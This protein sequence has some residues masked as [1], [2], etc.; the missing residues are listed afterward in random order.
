MT[1]YTNI[2]NGSLPDATLVMANFN[3]LALPF[4]IYT[5]TGFNST[6]SGG[7]GTDEQSVELTAITTPLPTN[8]V[9]IEITYAAV[10]T[11][12]TGTTPNASI[13]IQ[14]KETGGAYGDILA[15][16]VVSACRSGS[17]AGEAGETSVTNTIKYI[18]TPTAGEKANG[19]QLKVFSKSITDGA[20][21]TAN[22]T[23]VQTLVYVL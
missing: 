8:Y 21:D 17:N 4:Q 3:A 5:G 22:V 14:S 23:N 9:V 11:S 2:T 19:L 10:T 20:S 6:K 7:S 13:K 16:T 15:Y 18:H 1:A 12:I